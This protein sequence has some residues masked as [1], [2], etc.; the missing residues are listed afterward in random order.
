MNTKKPRTLVDELRGASRL[1]IEATR[2]VTDLVESMHVTV[3]GGPDLLGRPLAGIAQALTRPVYASI[4]GATGIVGA[5]IDRALAQ[6]APLVGA[7]EAGPER[8]MLLAALNGVLGDYLAE[9]N[10]PLAVEMRFRRGGQA[11]TL[12]RAALAAAFPEAAAKVLVLVHGSCMNDRMWR[13]DG[14]DHGAA[15]ARELG[16]SPL[17]L[18]YNSGLHVSTNGRAFAELLEQLA[19][20]WPVPLTELVILAHSMGGLVTRSAC[21]IAEADGLSW[22]QKLRAILFLG[23]PHDGAPLERGGNWIDTALGVSRYSAPLARLGKIRSAGVTD[24]RFGNVLDEHWEGRDR[25]ALDGDPRATLQ[26]PNGVDCYAV[27]GTTAGGPGRKLRGDGLVPLDSALGR[28]DT[29]ELVLRFPA[30]RCSIAYGVTHLDLL[31]SPDVYAT[32]RG[33]LA[34]YG[35]SSSDPLSGR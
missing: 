12:E 19:A 26:L 6:L 23:T 33:W 29:P 13:R 14:H 15:L 16:L 27:V 4:R 31:S 1:A 9:S 5:G 7:S 24:L 10:N 20:A 30:S 25:F 8:E 11:L 34:S 21:H 2:G 22:R 18:H 28:H 3:A 32:L 17:Y 35:G